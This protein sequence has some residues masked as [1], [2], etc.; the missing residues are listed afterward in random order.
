MGNFRHFLL[1]SLGHWL[2]RF[3]ICLV[4]VSCILVILMQ[5]R[6]F[7]EWVVSPSFLENGSCL[8][9]PLSSLVVYLNFILFLGG[10]ERQAAPRC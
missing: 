3:E 9:L 5:F 2:L 1:A 4:I 6:I 10:R 8:V 7:Y